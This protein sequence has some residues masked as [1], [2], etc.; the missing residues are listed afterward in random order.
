MISDLSN[1]RA[2]PKSRAAFSLPIAIE[3]QQQAGSKSSLRVSFAIPSSNSEVRV[4]QSPTVELC[5]TEVGSSSSSAPC[6]PMTVS[7]LNSEAGGIVGV[8]DAWITEW[9]EWSTCQFTRRI[10]CPASEQRSPFSLGWRTR[11]RFCFSLSSSSEATLGSSTC[12][13]TN[14]AMLEREACFPE[15]STEILHGVPIYL[16]YLYCTHMYNPYCFF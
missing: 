5:R 4:H 10:E 3:G 12:A 2:V 8:D 16:K 6:A 9:T 7:P 15:N 11:Q 14:S 13:S 1:C